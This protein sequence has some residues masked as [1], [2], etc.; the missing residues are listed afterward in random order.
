[1]ATIEISQFESEIVLYFRTPETRIN[2]YTLASTLVSV[3]DAARE[4]NNVVNPGYEIEVVVTALADGSFKAVLKTVFKEIGNLFSKDT[5]KAI[6]IG[7]ISTY[8]YE[9]ALA[10]NRDV[11]VVVNEQTV[12]IEQG[13]TKIIV[14][15][16]IYEAKQLVEK[17][18]RFK[19]SM[20]RTFSTIGRDEHIDGF[21]MT[22]S[23]SEEPSV[24]IPRQSFQSIEAI[25]T[26]G[27]NEREIIQ[28]AELQIMRAILDKSTR[29]W[30][31]V[32]AGVTL[33][34]P[35]LDDSFYREFFDHRITVAP[36]DVLECDL[37][38]YQRKTSAA[39]IFTN[40]KYEV[41]NVVRHI[42]RIETEKLFKEQK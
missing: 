7:I 37:K 32:W 16:N 17:S 12:V 40:Y 31:F 22:K 13:D 24:T 15:K 9:K 10:P 35:V 42:P 30:E 5:L 20:S 33:S 26:D 18:S 11:R 8:I 38:M 6:I 4:A 14:P 1:V 19:E 27:R 21:A 3:A 29:K 34:A 23:V 2:A 28:H 39:G 25:P 41:I 36:G